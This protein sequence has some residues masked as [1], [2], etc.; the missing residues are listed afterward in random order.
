M[1]FLHATALIAFFWLAVH[2]LCRIYYKQNHA[3]TLLPISNNSASRGRR[4]SSSTTT[5]TV[6]KIHLK[7]QTRAFNAGYDY[8]AG[9]RLTRFKHWASAFYSSGVVVGFVGMIVGL[10]V[11]VWITGTSAF[12]VFIA[13][14]KG[15]RLQRRDF[16]EEP[17]S[18][19]IQPII[20]GVTVPL[21]H[22][23]IILIAVLLC[24]IVHELGHAVAGALQVSL[25]P[26]PKLKTTADLPLQLIRSHS[27]FRFFS[28]LDTIAK[29]RIIAAGPLHNL[30][31][32]I[33]LNLLTQTA[34]VVERTSGLGTAIISIGWK[35]LS[36]EGRLVVG[37]DDDSPLNSVLHVGS[38]VTG[39]DD[40][41]LAVLGNQ[42]SEYLLQNSSENTPW[43]GW[44]VP[45]PTYQGAS[46][47]CCEDGYPSLDHLCFDSLGGTSGKRCL[48]PIP[49]L[50]NTASVRCHREFDCG[51]DA[52]C[53]R[54]N[55]PILRLSVR[56]QDP[57][58]WSGPRK[59][60]WEQVT[61]GRFAPRFWIIPASL[62]R[63]FTN[64][65]DYLQMATLSLFFFNL[66]PLPHLDGAQFLTA[67]L[68]YFPLTSSFASRVVADPEVGMS[69]TTT[70]SHRVVNGDLV[71]LWQRRLAR[72]I[73][74]G[75][76]GLV[77]LTILPLKMKNLATDNLLALAR[78]LSPLY[79]YF[80]PLSPAS[81][82]S[83]L[84]SSEIGSSNIWRRR[85]NRDAK[86]NAAASDLGVSNGKTAN[87]EMPT[88]QLCLGPKLF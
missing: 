58:L 20:P 18:S 16:A 54:P 74:Y 13:P 70:A 73:Q 25:F 51:G 33:L 80:L 48:N 4:C 34:L 63:I 6:N 49:L 5:V 29:A 79:F 64:F 76:V 78:S 56:G 86:G 71:S 59:E 10:S 45:R 8:L 53:V 23:P 47:D 43:Y 77:V 84:S 62:L 57:V 27:L 88:K 7:I 87:G 46:P 42:W 9:R 65:Y 72:L 83:L 50:S 31:L 14:Y 67:L 24:Q 37:I 1:S 52:V 85:T 32:W 11:L 60:I 66:L 21:S 55:I 12:Q 17:G 22:L 81:T 28:S 2:V 35:D 36:Q 19:F 44:C 30:V 75:T 68:D 61:I 82:G 15:S 38:I 40:V 41:S 26:Q 3:S 39:L 69:T